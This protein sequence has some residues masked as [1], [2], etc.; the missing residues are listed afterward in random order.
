VRRLVSIAL[1]AAS[2][3]AVAAGPALA[4]PAST[5]DQQQSG[6]STAVGME[7][8]GGSVNRLAQTFTAGES[9]TLEHV[10]LDVQTPPAQTFSNLGATTSA[11]VEFWATDGT[12]TPSG[13]PLASEIVLLSTG[14]QAVIFGTAPAVTAGTGYAIVLQPDAA[15]TWS[16]AC[17]DPYAGGRAMAYYNNAWVSAGDYATSTEQETCLEDFAFDDW[18]VQ[19]AATPTPTPIPTPTPTLTSA[20]TATPTPTPTTRATLPPTTTGDGRPSGE[21]PAAP[22]ALLSLCSTAGFV[23][24]RRRSLMG[25]Q[26]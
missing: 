8:A 14:L 12:G 9:G 23:A 16:G 20:P 25:H 11:T 22:L 19:A 24:V 18:V 4:L 5:L 6:N 1:G 21:V 26:R 15:I 10:D 17:G 13:G 7:N 3:L 2:L